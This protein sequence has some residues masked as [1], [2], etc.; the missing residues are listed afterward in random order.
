[1]PAPVPGTR[2]A[3]IEAALHAFSE[4]GY[5]STTMSEVRRAA[6]ASTGS[7]Y[8]HFPTREHLAAAVWL[9]GLRRFQ[10]GFA[11]TLAKATSAEDG[12]R[13]GVR[14]HLRWVQDHPDLARLL[15]AGQD[16][17]VRRAAA[18][19]LEQLNA[20]FFAAVLDWHTG[21]VE[22]GALRDVPFD[23]VY[24]LWLGP[25]QELARLWLAGATR[26]PLDAYEAELADGAWAALSAP[27]GA[28]R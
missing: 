3:L 21:H 14:F 17:A 5:G 25:A 20:T 26:R 16:P 10:E 8:H 2:A 19:E 6:G 23:L 22:S 7:L 13:S 27:A 15:L 18:G 11:A 1:M 24:A 12:V 4:R 28:P 9:D